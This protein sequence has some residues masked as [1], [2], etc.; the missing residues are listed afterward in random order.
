MPWVKLDGEIPFYGEGQGWQRQK[1]IYE[2]PFYY[3]DYCLAQTM[4]LQFWARIREDRKKAWETYMAYTV[5]A[6]TKTFTQLIEGA[7]LESPFGNECLRQVCT[8]AMKWLES[9]DLSGLE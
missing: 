2:A 1:H 7:G 5:P 3:I 9:Y 8:A 4:A 6:G